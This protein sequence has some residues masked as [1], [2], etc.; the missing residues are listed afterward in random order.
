[1]AE[2]YLKEKKLFN[3]IL[4]DMAMPVMNG[5]ESAQKIRELEKKYGVSEKNRQF[6]CGYSAQV[7]LS[8]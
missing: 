5:F 6:I 7:S 3:I 1:M 8:K 4:M 2:K